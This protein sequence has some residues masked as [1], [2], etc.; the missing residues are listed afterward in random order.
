MSHNQPFVIVVN[1][2]VDDFLD[3]RDRQGLLRRDGDGAT[4]SVPEPLEM[5][6]LAL[7]AEKQDKQQQQQK[8]LVLVDPNKVWK[9]KFLHYTRRYPRFAILCAATALFLGYVVHV[10]TRPPLPRHVLAHDYSR[11]GNA[12][13]GAM[14]Y[15]C[16]FVS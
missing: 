13:R 2:S 11:T 6:L 7:V 4:T 12:D 3:E 1:S 9:Q 15:K 8:S 5:E 16:L 10:K 14:D